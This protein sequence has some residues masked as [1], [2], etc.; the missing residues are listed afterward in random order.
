MNYFY[1]H[2]HYQSSF[3]FLFNKYDNLSF[4]EVNLIKILINVLPNYLFLYYYYSSIAN[5][6]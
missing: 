2:F 1:F 4:D 3:Y 5:I 6:H